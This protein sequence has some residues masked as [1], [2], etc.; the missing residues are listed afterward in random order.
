MGEISTKRIYCE[1]SKEMLS[2]YLGLDVL[3][4]FEAEVCELEVVYTSTA[5]F[6]GDV[7][8]PISKL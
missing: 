3:R 6:R 2:L 1:I 8:C 4:Q 7:A 5:A